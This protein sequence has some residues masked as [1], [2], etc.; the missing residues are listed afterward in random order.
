MSDIIAW[1]SVSNATS[2]SM[3]CLVGS[4]SRL[5]KLIR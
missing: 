2:T 4:S 3:Q 1:H 5:V